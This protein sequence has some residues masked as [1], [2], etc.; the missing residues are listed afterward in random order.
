MQR[1]DAA[2]LKA[3]CLRQPGAVEEFPFSPGVSVFKVAGKVFAL[4][5][6]DEA[7]L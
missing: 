4:S 5:A 1:M 7:P 2:E 3:W 6:L